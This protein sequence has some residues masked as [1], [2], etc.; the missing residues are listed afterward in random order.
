MK[1]PKV[2][3]NFRGS[4]HSRGRFFC[5]RTFLAQEVL[6]VMNNL[7]ITLSMKLFFSYLQKKQQII[8]FFNY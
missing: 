8:L 6:V 1:T 2:V 3:S 5:L 4:H 7:F